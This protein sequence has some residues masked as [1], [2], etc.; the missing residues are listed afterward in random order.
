MIYTIKF[1]PGL[2][3]VIQNNFL[4]GLFSGRWEGM[5]VGILHFKNVWLLFGRDFSSEQ[6]FGTYMYK[7]GS[8]R[9]AFIDKHIVI[10]YDS[11]CIPSFLKVQY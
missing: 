5:E 2:I 3:F 7:E 8:H 9:T 4:V 11:V 6:F 10:I 1:R